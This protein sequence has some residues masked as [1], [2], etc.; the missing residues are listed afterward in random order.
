MV[1]ISAKHVVLA[2]VLQPER[3]S[4]GVIRLAMALAVLVSHSYF[5]VTG[6]PQNEPLVGITGHSLGEHAVQ[7]FFF[8]SGVLVTQSY[9]KSGSVIDFFA[10]RALRIFPGLIVCVLATALLL[11]PAV[12]AVGPVAY[13]ADPMLWSYIVKTLA[14][15]TGSAP[16]PAT[17][18]DLPAAGLVNMSLWTLKYEMLCYGVLGLAGVGGIFA[19]RYRSVT[20][21]AFAAFVAVV[22]IKSP[23]GDHEYTSLENVRYFALYFATGVL[24]CLLKDVLVLNG[25]AVAATGAVFAALV[26]TAFGELACAVFLGYATLYVASFDLGLLRR[27]THESDVSF[28]VYI[29]AAPIQQGLVW[30]FPE[31]GP[32]GLTVLAS[33][34]VMPVALASW[35]AVE[36]PALSV[37]RRVV[38]AI[39]ARVCRHPR[40]PVATV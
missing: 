6:N 2:D 36:K 18:Q 25:I 39:R 22:F 24:A 15:V 40:V 30:A 4:F 37:R 28:G 11:G 19:P 21:A 12:S 7:V 8:L 10:A 5:F 16:L 3:N 13:Y 14:L 17:F 33:M 31:L 27:M 23:S 9:L 32:L 1:R 29:Y 35:L 20:I 26:G 34:I 38:E